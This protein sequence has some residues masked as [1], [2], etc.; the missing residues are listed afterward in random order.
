MLSTYL[1]L[2]ARIISYPVT[3]RASL[4][5]DQEEYD[6]EYDQR[7]NEDK[8][9][10]L[11]D[12][13]ENDEAAEEPLMEELNQEED[14]VTEDFSGEHNELATREIALVENED[15]GEEPLM[16]ELNQ[17]KDPVTEDS[18]GEHNELATREIAL[19][20]NEDAGEEPLM[21]ELNQEED[22]V[23]ED[24]SGEHSE[25]TTREIALVTQDELELIHK[26][27]EN[28]CEPES[29]E[30][31]EFASQPIKDE[32]S[33]DVFEVQVSPEPRP[34]MHKAE[35]M[36]GMPKTKF[37]SE[38]DQLFLSKSKSQIFEAE[39]ISPTSMDADLTPVDHNIEPVTEPEEIAHNIGIA[40]ESKSVPE[41]MDV[42]TTSQQTDNPIS[43]ENSDRGQSELFVGTHCA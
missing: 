41:Q 11:E 18:S 35:S 14:P 10:I 17:E 26:S 28:L 22:P 9:V 33:E 16:E 31:Q 39:S 43:I 40:E 8:D 2:I 15:A 34:P 5:E 7:P 20:E 12:E 23:T 29:A 19:V 42:S 1:S 38:E 27:V 32:D 4:E 13:V 3:D 21:E 37:Y 30:H 25:L 6:Q 36:P 24:S